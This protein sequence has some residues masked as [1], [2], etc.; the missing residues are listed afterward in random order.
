MRKI[1]TQIISALRSGTGFET[2]RDRITPDGKVYLWDNLVAHV[3]KKDYSMWLSDSGWSTQTTMRRLNAV[4]AAV[5][6]P[7]SFQVSGKTTVC[8]VAGEKREEKTF[9]VNGWRVTVA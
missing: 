3:N 9:F 1:E 6:L 7:V 8:K 4:T 2:V 5:G